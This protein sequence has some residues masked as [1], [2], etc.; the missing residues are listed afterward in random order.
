MKT[1]IYKINPT[2][3]QLAIM[4]LY[5]DMFQAEQSNLWI[6]IGELEREM[7]KKTGIEELEFFQD[8]ND[9]VGIGQ[10]NREMRLIYGED[11]K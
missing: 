9:W 4:K 3:K 11:L 5:W 1:K 2:K 8:D 6:R 10:G 7:S